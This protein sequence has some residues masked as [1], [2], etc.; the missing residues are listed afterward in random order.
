MPERYFDLSPNDKKD[1]LETA[2]ERSGRSPHLLEKDVWLVWTLA[3]LFR[4]GLGADLT[5]KGGTSLSK[6]Y[7][8]INRFS[9][10]IT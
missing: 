6:A 7:Q 9:E 10:D 2:A 8:A 1:L 5:L 3:A 4:S